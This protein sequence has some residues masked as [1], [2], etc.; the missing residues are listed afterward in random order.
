MQFFRKIYNSPPHGTLLLTGWLLIVL[1]M[2]T[3]ISSGDEISLV[4]LF[5]VP[6]GLAAYF[7]PMR[8]CE[9]EKAE[10]LKR[11]LMWL[12]VFAGALILIVEIYKYAT[13][14]RW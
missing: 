11:K 3:A 4:N 6:I 8:L 9:I 5:F 10:A 2:L 7:L 1:A 12:L 13:G 14:I